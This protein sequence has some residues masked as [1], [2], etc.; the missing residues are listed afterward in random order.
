MLY[1]PDAKLMLYFGEASR[2]L[3]INGAKIESIFFEKVERFQQVNF[4][5][6]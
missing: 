2:L 5:K 6:N 3:S 4:L 1:S